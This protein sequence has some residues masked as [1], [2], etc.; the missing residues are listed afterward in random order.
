MIFEIL[1]YDFMQR[2]LLSGSVIAVLCSVMGIFLVLRR[3]SLFGDALAHSSFGGAALGLFLGIY[4]LWVA[5]VFS[6]ISAIVITRTRERFDISGD[7]A[8]AVLLAS[9]IA[10]AL[11]MIGLSGGFSI[12]VFSFLFGSILLVSAYDTMFI[13]ALTGAIFIVILLLFRQILYST[14]DEKQAKVSGIRVERI[15][16]LLILMA[17]LTVVTATQLVGVLLISASF[18]IPNIT[19]MILGRGFLGTM[20][21]SITIAVFSVI[22][23]IIISYIVNIAPAGCIVLLT[24]SI[25]VG[26]MATTKLKKLL[27]KEEQ[28]V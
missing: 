12:D 22:V 10:V 6:I 17:G 28:T 21:V 13:L 3:Y 15:N 4:P 27:H 20:I 14:F 7:A 11:V 9:G 24:I 26:V 18:V 16:Y 8:I 25:L 19:A 1:A 2:A 5:Y 23:G